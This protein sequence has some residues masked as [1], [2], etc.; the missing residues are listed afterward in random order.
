MNAI[1][2]IILIGLVVSGAIASFDWKAAA[3][4]PCP[5]GWT[6]VGTEGCL[7]PGYFVCGAHTGCPIGTTCGQNKC[8]G[9]PVQLA[10]GPACGD[11]RCAA[12]HLCGV[13]PAGPGCYDP[14]EQFPCGGKVCYKIR[15]YAPGDPCAACA[16][17]RPVAASQADTTLK[18]AP[19]DKKEPEIVTAVAAARQ[20]SKSVWTCAGVKSATGISLPNGPWTN[21]ARS[22]GPE[23]YCLPAGWSGCGMLARSWGCPPRQTCLGVGTKPPYCH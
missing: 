19:T 6:P 18:D 3:A 17:K 20:I 23:I 21:A 15:S 10:T 9:A 1:R 22:G 7:E 4:A 5:A 13:G 12:G 14:S 2:Q 16:P 11:T 8:L